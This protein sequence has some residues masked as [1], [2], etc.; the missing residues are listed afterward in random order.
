MVKL[1]GLYSPVPGSGKSEAAKA[2][3]GLGWRI[4]PF[5]ATLKRMVVPLLQDLGLSDAAIADR[6]ATGKELPLEALD[7][8]PL[9]RILQLL[10][11]EFGRE[12]VHRDLWLRCWSGRVKP[13]LAAGGSV[14]VDDV[15]FPEEAALVEELG[16]RMWKISRPTA[17]LS[18][19]IRDAK[20]HASEGGLDAWLFS[21]QLIN[22][23]DLASW[24]TTVQEAANGR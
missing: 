17:D 5:A 22:H 18:W 16:G 3:E 7:G 4:E 12:M 10:G 14:V 21:R 13:Q 24:H 23:G 2:L 19:R 15:R 1:I 9:R 11:T 6:L 20:P 8:L